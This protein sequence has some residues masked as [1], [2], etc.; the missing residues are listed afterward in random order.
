MHE[1]AQA[2]HAGQKVGLFLAIPGFPF[3]GAVIAHLADRVVIGQ[4]GRFRQAQDL[5]KQAQD[6]LRALDEV[7]IIKTDR[8]D[9]HGPEFPFPAHFLILQQL[10]EIADRPGVIHHRVADGLRVLGELVG[11][12]DAGLVGDMQGN[13]LAHDIAAAKIEENAIA[14]QAQAFAFGATRPGQV[15]VGDFQAGYAILG[16]MGR[17]DPLNEGGP[18]LR[19]GQF[20]LFLRPGR[21]DPLRRIPKS[22][23]G[24]E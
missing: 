16:L 23:G 9:R 12:P 3:R 24:L 15:R 8:L 5:R 17:Q 18:G 10:D 20:Q 19:A 4:A 2:L 21:P 11:M 22:A 13:G 7:F 6:A 14:R 1:G